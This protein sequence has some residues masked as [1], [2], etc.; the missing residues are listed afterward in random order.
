V[1]VG[2][3]CRCI[4]ESRYQDERCRQF[5]AYPPAPA[6]PSLP[7]CRV[8][9]ADADEVEGGAK[10]A[11]AGP[12]TV[13]SL[14]I[15]R[16]LKSLA[17]DGSGSMMEHSVQQYWPAD[18]CCG[19]FASTMHP[20]LVLCLRLTS[21]QEVSQEA[22][23]SALDCGRHEGCAGRPAVAAVGQRRC[24]ARGSIPGCV[25]MCVRVCVRTFTLKTNEDTFTLHYVYPPKCVHRARTTSPPVQR[26]LHLCRPHCRCRQVSQEVP[27]ENC[28]ASPQ[29][30]VLYV[31]SVDT[32]LYPVMG[33]VCVCLH[34]TFLVRVF[35]DLLN[36]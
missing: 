17:P 10:A 16:A 9:L 31:V 32:T 24:C 19:A 20:V 26:V 22:G 3:A 36:K 5:S 35:S 8:H 2:G 28:G 7:W 1:V 12:G 13:P 25:Q 30:Y 23:D 15:A 27:Q 14:S 11:E 33:C 18:V 34:R 29:R 6:Q 21:A 4:P